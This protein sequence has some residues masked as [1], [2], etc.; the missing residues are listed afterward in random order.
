MNYTLLRL[1]GKGGMAEVWYAENQ[2][3]KPA[4]VKILNEDL[5]HNAQIVERFRNEAKITVKL[6]HPNIRQVYD[7]DEVDGR[8]C[9]V[10]E[11][12]E[13]DDLS[14]RMKRGERFTDE[15][16]KKWW[17]QIADA[18]NYT[19]AQGVVHRDIKPSNIFIDREGNVKLL[20][21]GI[22]KV[23][24]SITSTATG[25]TMG[26]LMYMS[27]EQV[28]DSKRIDEKTDLYSLAVTFVHLLTGQV[29]YDY[30]TTDDFEIRNNIVNIPLDM[31]GVPAEWQS[32][33][34]PYLAKNPAERP[35]LTE[36]GVEASPVDFV[37]P[38][39]PLVAPSAPVS[40]VTFV[41]S[42][43]VASASAIDE[44]TMAETPSA[45][46]QPQSQSRKRRV[47]PWMLAVCAVVAAVVVCVVLLG[48]KKG[49]SVMKDTRQSVA[50]SNEDQ[51]F[52]VGNASFTMKS[53]EGGTFQMGGND[54]DAYDDEKPVHDVT[55]SSFYMGETEVTQ[56]LWQAVM[57]DNPSHFKGDNLPVEQVSWNDCQDFIQK[58]NE[59]VSEQLPYG[60]HFALPTEAQWEYAARGGNRKEGYKYSGSNTIGNVAWHR[61]NSG[62]STH[63]VKTKAVNELGLYDMSGNV[64][65]WCADWYG[66]YSSLEQTDPL[67][68][69]AGSMRVLR[70]CNWSIDASDFRVSSRGISS[71]GYC[72]YYF[73]FRLAL[74][75]Q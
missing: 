57:G 21:F 70:G 46:P 47:W 22:A 26:T 52:T 49:S 74:V 11:Y 51:S 17:N 13:G 12:L 41:G 66:D 1:L 5:S 38:V 54:S 67:G 50:F 62:S 19:H 30:D 61:D 29:P 9:I 36:F 35:A 2:I 24:D 37:P 18:L 31:T 10:M 14:L 20:D 59:Q 8:P 7:Y 63:P 55:L 73:G 6:N 32:F 72:N 60:W 71:P 4:A 16:L 69:S 43:T 25:A 42:A 33:L 58:L 65:E 28:R 45:Q 23:R 75:R 48:G 39:T 3:E 53:V 15:Q 64:S 40:E 34:S 56:A 44:G 68:P 27:P